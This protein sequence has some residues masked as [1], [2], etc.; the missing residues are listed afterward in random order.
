[1]KYIFLSDRLY[2]S[3][4]SCMYFLGISITGILAR[5]LILA[6]VSFKFS[7]INWYNTQEKKYEL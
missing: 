3:I 5:Q 1:M 4:F 2:F 7:A 6:T